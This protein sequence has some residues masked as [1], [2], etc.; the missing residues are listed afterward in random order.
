MVTQNDEKNLPECLSNFA[1]FA[2]EIVIADIGS[3]DRT[4]EIAEK[5]GA[6]VI[7]INWQRNLSEAA[8]ACIDHAKG[9]WVLFLQPNETIPKEYQKVILDILDN[10]N[11]EA[12]VLNINYSSCEYAV[13]CLVNR[14]RL[15][16]RRGEYR[17]KYRS[18]SRIPDEVLTNILNSD[19]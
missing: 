14:L 19:A 12:Y 10:P 3:T 7:R 17:F 4:I 8:N 11:A 16:R 13:N 2:D 9:K 18:Y 15:F 5:A 6:K 1:E